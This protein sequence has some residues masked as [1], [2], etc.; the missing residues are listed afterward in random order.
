MFDQAK[1]IKALEAYF[2]T[3]WG[4]SVIEGSLG[5]KEA[6]K[7]WRENKLREDLS[8]WLEWA[9]DQER[10]ADALRRLRTPDDIRS[11]EDLE[12]LN[13][14]ILVISFFAT[15]DWYKPTD[16]EGTKIKKHKECME[17]ITNQVK[18]IKIF[19]ESLKLN[20]KNPF[21]PKSFH[22]GL[23][24]KLEVLKKEGLTPEENKELD[25]LSL[26][27]LDW[28]LESYQLSL[29]LQGFEPGQDNSS[30][31]FGVFMQR[32]THGVLIYPQKIAKQA[33]REHAEINSYLFHLA[34]VFRQ[35]TD[36]TSRGEWLTRFKGEMPD[37]GGARYE[38]VADLANALFSSIGWIEDESKELTNKKV[39]ERIKALTDKDV[40]LGSWLTANF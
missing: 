23:L 1:V 2:P 21:Q 19:R 4:P 8:K 20:K 32:T 3:S 25:H 39:M 11:K 28:L 36:K 17:N 16:F 13:S 30:C 26:E 14:H 31:G 5:G 33:V 40:K 15:P 29:E 34:M 12:E 7:K 22:L 10:F 18:G 6:A 9:K 35:F 37:C 24:N 27:F 38:N